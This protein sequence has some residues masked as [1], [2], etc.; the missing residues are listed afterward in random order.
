MMKSKYINEKIFLKKID[1]NNNIDGTFVRGYVLEL[2]SS[3]EKSLSI[4][5]K[6]NLINKLFRKS[7][8]YKSPKQIIEDNLEIILR[9]ID[10][11]NVGALFE[12][13]IED[14]Q[15]LQIIKNHMD[16]IIARLN[17]IK[18]VDEPKVNFF[19]ELREKPE[20][21]K[22]ISDNI[23]TILAGS[24]GINEAF[25]L[26]GISEEID[27]KLNEKL[28]KDKKKVAKNLIKTAINNS[29]SRSWDIYTT[30]ETEKLSD[31][32]SDVLAQ[33][34]DELLESEKVRPIDIELLGTGSYSDVF[35][36]GRQVLKIGRARE[37]YQIPNH[38]R[39]LQPLLRTNFIDT[40]N[41]DKP[42]ACVEIANCVEK[43]SK[44]DDIDEVLYEIYRDLREAGIVWTDVRA[45]NIGKLKGPNIPELNG[46]KMD[47]SPI[48]IGFKEK[49]KGGVHEN[50]YFVI[51]D[52]DYIYHEDSP[53][54]F[55]SETE[56]IY[57]ERYQNEI[58][59]KTKAENGKSEKCEKNKG[60]VIE[61]NE[62]R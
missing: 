8:F 47:V 28:I 39:I 18:A 62:E 34:I 5:P 49:L 42:F 53:H 60:F 7:R 36:V 11:D 17:N 10:D 16:V 46:E 59:S 19:K 25:K 1:S 54:L 21:E 27:L 20:G 56:R 2:L 48:S 37:T 33:I 4:F 14:E 9:K 44:E 35:Q 38:P 40:Q 29:N 15:L 57:R 3:E 43:I 23:E 41:N 26:K 58:N 30:E 12:D 32:Y 51:L 52:T 61:H 13:F 50:G 6:Y 45:V 55:R 24:L 31:E 22:I